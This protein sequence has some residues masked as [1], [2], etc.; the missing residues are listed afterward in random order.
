[1]FAFTSCG[2][3]IENFPK[4]SIGPYIFKISGQIHLLIGSLLPTD[5]NPPRFARL[6]I[7]IYMIWKMK[8]KLA[9]FSFENESKDLI[10]IIIEH[11]ITML[12]NTNKLVKIF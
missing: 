10:K 8:F 3:N 7:Y 4:N 12:D 9:S 5:N 1:M 11:L 2:S 6:Y